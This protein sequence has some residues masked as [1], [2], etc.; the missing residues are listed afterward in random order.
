MSQAVAV[1]VLA[2]VSRGSV[3]VYVFGHL[4]DEGVGG[5]ARWWFD[6]ACGGVIVLSG[7]GS[8]AMLAGVVDCRVRRG[9]VGHASARRSRADACPALSRYAGAFV[10]DAGVVVLCVCV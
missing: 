9:S 1:C 3:L 10:L 2:V 5:T 6:S 7:S 4:I 8:R